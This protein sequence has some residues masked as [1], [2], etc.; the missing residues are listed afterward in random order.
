[1]LLRDEKFLIG[2]FSKAT[3]ARVRKA[4]IREQMFEFWQ[5]NVAG[6]VVP[7]AIV[8]VVVVIVHVREFRVRHA[9]ESIVRIHRAAL[10]LQLRSTV[11]DSTSR[12]HVGLE[13]LIL[14]AGL[15]RE[16]STNA[17]RGIT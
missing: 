4:D 10:L 9:N 14:A 8:V 11:S 15:H 3:G 16:R 13:L 17:R 5:D 1:V 7:I 12:Q 6:T 2:G